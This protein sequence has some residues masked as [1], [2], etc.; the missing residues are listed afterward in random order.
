M[1]RHVIITIGTILWAIG[2]IVCLPH[3][4]FGEGKALP[5]LTFSH[6]RTEDV[7]AV[8]DWNKGYSGLL[9]SLVAGDLD[10]IRVELVNAGQ[11][12]AKDVTVR[13]YEGS[14]ISGKRYPIGEDVLLPR[15]S[16]GQARLVQKV[17]DTLGKAGRNRIYVQIDPDN[18]VEEL[19]EENNTI[20]MDKAVYLLGDFNQDGRISPIDEDLLKMALGSQP[21]DPGWNPICDIWTEGLP[22]PDLPN[23]RAE[24]DWIISEHADHVVF[25]GLMDLNLDSPY[26]EISFDHADHVVFSNPGFEVGNE[27]LIT[28]RFPTVGIAEVGEISVQFFNG[29]PDAGGQLIGESPIGSAEGGI[30]VAEI[31]WDTD[32]LLAGK[33]DIFVLADYDDRKVESSETNNLMLAA[34]SLEHTGI[35]DPGESP[36]P[37]AFKLFQN[38]PNPFNASTTITFNVCATSHTA[39][40]H[41]QLAIYNLLGHPVRTLVNARME[42]G[43][44]EVQWNALD[45]RHLPVSSGIYFFQ[46]TVDERRWTKVR[47]LVLIR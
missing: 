30:G 32:H 11:T 1:R 18:S 23:I 4:G 15:I 47:R 26:A 2:W 6:T 35:H 34:I 19:N 29:F 13:F 24:R 21:G 42:P 10:T 36:T 20:S 5:E 8:P 12:A 39:T 27:V 37:S 33:Y 45:D 25:S 44:W 16:P 31:I 9:P 7:E 28:A 38:V 3:V 17:W 14:L 22:F 43:I 46:M 41:V 40:P